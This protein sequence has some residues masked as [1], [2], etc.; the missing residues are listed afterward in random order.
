MVVLVQ[1]ENNMITFKEFKYAVD[2]IKKINDVCDKLQELRIDLIDSELH[3]GPNLLFDC[4]ISSH[5]TEIG[6]DL[7]SWWM[8]E[9]VNKI[10]YDSEDTSK[11]I[12]DINAT[13]DLWNYM[14][15]DPKV[16]FKNV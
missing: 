13:E 7:V 5:F 2:R 16:Y 3:E 6:Q 9:D 8:Y 11:I 15:N 4:F 10:L 1:Q 12:A 14:M